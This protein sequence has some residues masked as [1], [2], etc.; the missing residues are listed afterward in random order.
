MTDK[1]K[2]MMVENIKEWLK[3]D[4]EITKFQNEIKKRRNK[5]KELT[6]SLVIIMSTNNIDCVN[7]NGGS[8]LYKKNTI[9][10]PINSKMLINTLKSYY[11]TNPTQAEEITKYINLVTTYKSPKEAAE[12]IEKFLKSKGIKY[13]E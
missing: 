10:K 3:I 2:E 6:D 12:A 5:K 8:L 1:S 13:F 11:S 4:N 9:K 7:I